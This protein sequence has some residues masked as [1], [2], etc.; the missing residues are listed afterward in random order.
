MFVTVKEYQDGEEHDAKVLGGG[1]QLDEFC[2]DLE[3]G[4][5]VSLDD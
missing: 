2:V 4:E 5:L 1:M 3:K